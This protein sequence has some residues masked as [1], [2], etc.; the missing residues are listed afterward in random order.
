MLFQ[1]VV[2][3][4]HH[5]VERQFVGDLRAA[6]DIS[7]LFLDAAP[8]LAQF[9]DGAEIFVG[10]IDRRLDPRLLNLR[11]AV[12]VGH[13][14][15]VVQLHVARVFG[16][17]AAQFQLVDHRRRGGD[18]V[19]VIFAGQPLLD[20][21]EV[22]QP[23]ETAAEAEAQRG[24]ALGLEAEAGIVEAQLADAFAQ[25]FKVLGVG[26]EQAAEHH[27]L[28]F[29][30]AGQRLGGGAF[31]VGDGV[32]DAGLRDFLDL[33]GD[34]AD[35]ARRDFG[36]D[37]HLGPHAADAVDQMLGA[38]GH[39]LDLLALFDDAVDHADQD[40]DAEIGVVPA[41]DEHRLQRRVA[42]ALWRGDAG[43]DG[44]QHLVDADARFG[45]GQDRVV[46][47]QADDFLD[48]GL[49]LVDF[50]GGQVDLVDD[51]DD[52]M[53]MLDRLVDIGE[54]LRLYALRRIDD[55]QRAFACGEAAATS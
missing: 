1:P 19:E 31:G 7:Q 42:V 47:G 54:R 45:A 35:L 44:L 33:R 51:G 46:G 52:F 14:G 3:I 11:D 24:A 29:L 27:R 12:D 8:V 49:D 2:E 55:E 18:Q 4:E 20:D 26:R 48:L 32:A 6:A 22:E 13:V 37:F 28:H 38:G 23:K 40:D 21:F 36:Q 5:F 10:D 43:D 16:L 39:E 25:F 50:G 9:Q 30:E 17:A 34:E 41:V 15:G 53:V